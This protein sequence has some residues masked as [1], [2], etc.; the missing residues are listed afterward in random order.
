MTPRAACLL[1]LSASTTLSLL[2]A[3]FLV[4]VPLAAT[5]TPT[6][7]PVSPSIFF[8]NALLLTSSVVQ[9]AAAGNQTF[10]GD[11]C[12]NRC[13]STRARHYFTRCAQSYYQGRLL[14]FGACN[15]CALNGN[16]GNCSFYSTSRP[17]FSNALLLTCI[18]TVLTA[19]RE[20]ARPR[21]LRSRPPRTALA[22]IIPTSRALIAARTEA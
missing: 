13:Q 10:S 19:Q 4:W 3:S 16:A 9:Q 8:P 21:W 5:M 12:C 15:E 1:L 6:L 22:L 18:Q 20:A 2:S 14:N 17:R 7:R 11:C